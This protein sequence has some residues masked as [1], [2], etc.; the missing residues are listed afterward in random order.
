[1]T[2]LENH[3]T[4]DFP[5]FP[6]R[7]L[8][9]VPAVRYAAFASLRGWFPALRASVFGFFRLKVLPAYGL[10]WSDRLG[11]RGRRSG[12]FGHSR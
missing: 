3:L 11:R 1:M 9:F 12:V 5:D 6:D 4:A 7:F 2:I 10:C 8:T